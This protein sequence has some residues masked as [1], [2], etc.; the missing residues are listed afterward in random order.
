MGHDPAFLFYPGD[1]M[2][3]TMTFNRAQ[4]GAYMDLLMAQY[5]NGRLS[6]DDIK[7]VLGVDFDSMWLSKLK[8]KFQTDGEFYWSERLRY[9]VEKRKNYTESRRLARTKAREDNVRIY[10][11]LDKDSGYIKIGSSVNPLRRYNEIANQ[12]ISVVGSSN[13]RNYEL[14]WY[15]GATERVKEI[16]L[17]DH[18]KNKNIS[19]EWF[20]LNDEDI[21][22]IQRTL[23]RTENENE[24]ENII[25]D[26]DIKIKGEY[27]GEKLPPR[28]SIY[29]EIFSTFWNSYCKVTKQ[30]S[31]KEPAYR[32]WKVLTQEER[33]KAME[34]IQNY[35][36]DCLR[37][38]RPAKMAKTYLKDRTFNNDFKQLS[39][40]LP[41]GKRNFAV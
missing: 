1:W 38:K 29:S 24:N 6:I 7:I 30:I 8:D 32:E 14:L 2:G 35:Y 36:E 4:K 15:S 28:T 11:L 39:G 13:E 5:N 9:E 37:N 41:N 16:E 25:K 23:P 33:N 27:E 10:L 3:G 40:F 22:M 17:H 19:G 20:S 26:G 21:R 12:T 31:D 18:F 34:N